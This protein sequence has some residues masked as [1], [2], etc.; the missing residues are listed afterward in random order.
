[1]EARYVIGRNMREHRRQLG[2][3]QEELAH[4][5]GLHPVELGRAERGTR[6]MRITTLVKI[7]RGL[8]VPPMVLLE[9][10]E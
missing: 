9:G 10:V 5:A 3:T 1:M 8:Q 2:L 7:A 6:D 4:R